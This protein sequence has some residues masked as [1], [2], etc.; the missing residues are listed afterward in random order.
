MEAILELARGRD[1][2]RLQ[3]IEVARRSRIGS[4]VDRGHLVVPEV[5]IVGPGPQPLLLVVERS[6][7]IRVCAV[8]ERIDTRPRRG[9]LAPEIAPGRP[10]PPAGG[11]DEDDSGDWNP[12]HQDLVSAR[13]VLT[14]VPALHNVGVRPERR[15]PWSSCSQ[16]TPDSSRMTEIFRYFLELRRFG[17]DA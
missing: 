3:L 7:P 6:L 12:A 2:A 14:A 10:V 13:P 9:A 4:R 15:R 5:Q 16:C 11:E 17:I 1:R 8:R